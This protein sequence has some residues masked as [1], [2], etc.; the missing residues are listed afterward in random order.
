MVAVPSSLRRPQNLARLA[1]LGFKKMHSFRR[2]RISLLKQYTGRLYGTKDMI[3]E[4]SSGLGGMTSPINLI[5]QAVTTLVP[6]LVYNNP[7]ARIKSR[8]LAYREYAGISELA[9]NHLIQEVHLRDTMRKVITDAIFMAG[10]VKVG[11]GISGQT[12]DID[13]FWH[14]IGQPYCDRVDGDD[15]VLD[16]LSR[17]WEEQRIIGNRFRADLEPL[18][19]S[20]LYDPD[21]LRQ[22]AS[23]YSMAGLKESASSLSG[24]NTAQ[25]A[26]A[27]TGAIDLVDLW[28][29][30]DNT[31]VTMPWQPDNSVAPTILRE[32]EYEGPEAGPYRM[33]GFAMVP[34]NIMPVAP[35]SMWNDLGVMANR[36]ASKI[37]QQSEREKS[38]LAYESTAW[39]DAQGVVEADDGE[40]VRVDN[41]D[42]IKEVHYGG[43]QKEGYMYLEWI[44][45]QFSDMAMN[46][47][48]LS[49]TT[50]GEPTAT[51]AEMLQAN[52]TVRLSD[53]Q[54][55]VY[56][57]TG[58]LMT[59]LFFFL[60]TDPLIELP[61]VKR[62]QGEDSQVFYTPEMREGDWMDYNI[63]VQPY[64][65]ARQDPNVKIRRLLEFSGNVIPALAGAAQMLG[66]AFNLEAAITLI[67]REMGI[68]ELD[69]IINS[70]AL[71]MQM[72]NMQSLLEMGVPLDPGVI[73]TMMGNQSGAAAGGGARPQ[74]PNPRAALQ[75]GITTGV[76]TNMR[77]QDTAAELQPAKY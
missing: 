36:I 37:G 29:P 44:K 54:E 8:F 15:M 23:R 10:F 39:Q 65:M 18:Q 40:S 14:D 69:E 57:F 56:N 75:G 32:V 9:M 50:T 30:D 7:K 70:P 3:G 71:Q 24:Q 43:V 2:A 55:I 12:L 67:G 5:Y 13:G 60:H 4:Y 33:L 59:T 58:E 48:L 52:T 1:S 63:S 22:L 16:P 20:G 64:S 35:A 73:Q 62:S 42:G 38:V 66:P 34:D 61:L 26:D 77:R 51:Q 11:L 74:Q 53:M 49:G 25:E 45:N 17:E 46:I 76:E 31:I 41:I 28:L 19:E 68:E 47:D 72:Q 21:D 27:V 6:N